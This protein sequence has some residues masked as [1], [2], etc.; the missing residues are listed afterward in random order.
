MPIFQYQITIDESK[1]QELYALLQNLRYVQHVEVMPVENTPNFTP[2]QLN[3][4]V[5]EIQAIA[6]RFPPDKKWTYSDIEKYF[7]PDLKVKVEIINN[8]LSIMATPKEDHQLIVAEL[9]MTMGVFAKQNKL[10]Q[11]YPAPL[12]VIFDENN[13]FQPDVLFI[14]VERKAT[15]IDKNGK[16]IVAP[17]IAVEI[18][19]PSNRKKERDEKRSIYENF[20]VTEYWS[21][22]PKKQHITVETLNEVGKYEVFS[23]A[24]TTGIIKSKVLEGFEI[25][26][27]ELIPTPEKEIKEAQEETPKKQKKNKKK[28]NKQ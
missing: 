27:A 25:D 18:W 5:A 6:Q 8:K 9:L 17:D 19:S 3:Y 28:H 15:A 20:G 10:G 7:P 12:D 14:K 1:V 23:E 16:I 2:N 21:I 4:S 11:L 13:V 24:K 26:V 22:Y